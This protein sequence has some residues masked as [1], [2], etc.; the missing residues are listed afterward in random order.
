MATPNGVTRP[1]TGSLALRLTALPPEASTAPLRATA[2]R[3]AT[4]PT[5]NYHDNLLS[6]C[7]NGQAYPGAPNDAQAARGYRATLDGIA[8]LHFESVEVGRLFPDYLVSDGWP[9]YYAKAVI[10]D[11]QDR[12]QTR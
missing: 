10:R 12:T 2:A 4:W 1:I 9:T 8:G 3:S 5:D 11:A 6:G 7:K